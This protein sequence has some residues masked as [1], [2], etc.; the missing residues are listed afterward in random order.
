MTAKVT[1]AS[2]PPL[3]VPAP[4]FL[5][6]PIA[7]AAAG[8]LLSGSD[9]D[10]LV[11]INVPR[12][13]AVTHAVIIGWL[14]TFMI[15]AVYQLGPAVLGGRLASHRLAQGHFVAHAGSAA[16]FVWAVER[17]DV[18]VM[19]AAGTV[20][21]TSFGLFFVN[22]I[23]ATWRGG[24]RTIPALYLRVSITMLLGAISL[25][26]LTALALSQ[27][28]WPITMGRLSAHAHVG[29]VGWLAITLTGVSYQL[30]P[31]FMVIPHAKLRMAVPAL[32]ITT[33]ATVVFATG[34][35]FDPERPVR[36]ALAALLAAG[37]ALWGITFWRLLG[38]RKRR[39]LDIQGRATVV[40]LA[41]LAATVVLGMGAA[42][43]TPFTPDEQPARWLLAYG[44]AGLGGWLGTALI[45]NSFKIVPFLVWF[46]RYHEKVGQGAVP[47]LTDM[48]SERLAHVVLA[49]HAGAVLTIVMGALSGELLLVQAG[50]VGLAA[51]A[52]MHLGV[53]LSVF[54]P[55]ERSS[56]SQAGVRRIAP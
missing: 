27:L 16:T 5:A 43:G 15:G 25:G 7:L 20:L 8:L 2:S 35:A 38:E 24:K 6:A 21:F 47:L 18:H 9:P 23:P 26:L 36:L 51:G 55:H 40:S 28:W 39:Q 12:T 32:A 19:A 14:T 11:A 48:F 45:G 10:A 44:A 30:A 34:I 1:P 29:L 41:F 46:H 37:P 17:W 52:A 13:V 33:V 49:I 56:R 3:S 31:M 54:A 42:A 53:L 4:F 22:A 50:G